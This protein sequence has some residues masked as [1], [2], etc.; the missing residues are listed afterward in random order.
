MRERVSDPGADAPSWTSRALVG[1]GVGCVTVLLVAGVVGITVGA[2]QRLA[3]WGDHEEEGAEPGTEIGAGDPQPLPIPAADRDA[4]RPSTVADMQ[5]RYRPGPHVRVDSMVP[6][7]RL[8]L[9]TTP[10]QVIAGRTVDNPWIVPGS[11]LVPTAM[12]GPTAEGPRVWHDAAEPAGPL[13]VIARTP[14]RA[15]VNARDAR[16]GTAVV[17]YLVELA[18]YPGHFRLPA[19]APT[20]LGAVSAGGSEGATIHFAILS[21][22]MPGGAVAPAG[23]T[24]PV[25]MRLAAVDDQGRVSSAITRELSVVAVGAGDVEVTLTMSEP[26]D[27]DLYVTDPTGVTIFYGNTQA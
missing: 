10:G 16:G 20:E 3:G 4:P 22:I 13:T 8:V 27:L 11:Q 18:G 15:R 1:C 25:T 24:F 9:P 19:T 26:T 14:A 7:G 6:S 21:P 23:I 12:P 2:R 5:Q 17:A